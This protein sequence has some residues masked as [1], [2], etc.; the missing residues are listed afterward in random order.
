MIG[1]LFTPL[2]APRGDVRVVGRG[3]RGW[4]GREGRGGV[5]DEQHVTSCECVCVCVDE[6]HEGREREKYDFLWGGE[7]VL[8]VLELNVVR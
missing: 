2:P 6:S 4:E 8:V 3:R 7:K 1:S 5:P